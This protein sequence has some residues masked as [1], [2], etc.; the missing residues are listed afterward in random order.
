MNDD[1]RSDNDWVRMPKP[2]ERLKGLSRTTLLELVHAGHIKSATLRKG[3]SKKGI[4]LIFLPSLLNHL[5]TCVEKPK[6]GPQ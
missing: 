1:V 6:V 5:E 3:Q 2:K 4:R